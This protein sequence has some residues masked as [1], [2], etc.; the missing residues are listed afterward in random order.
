M[1]LT[2]AHESTALNETGLYPFV[3]LFK[4]FRTAFQG[5]LNE[6]HAVARETCVSGPRPASDTYIV[7][8]LTSKR[9][10]GSLPLVPPADIPWKDKKNVAVFRGA[11]TGLGRDGF[12]QLGMN[13]TDEEKCLHVQRCK[14]VYNTFGS[15]IVDAYITNPLPT[16][17][18]PTRIGDVQLTGPKCTLAE[19]LK[20][21]AI[22]M[23]EG[24]DVSSGFKW[25]LYSNSVVLTQKPR[26]SA[27]TMEDILEPWV[28]YV[29]LNSDLSDV[30]EKMQW[31]ID[32]DEE[33]QRIAKRAALWMKDLLYHPDSQKDEQ[34]IYEETIRRYRDHFVASSDL[35]L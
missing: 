14:L 26:L 18:L 19:M 22:I 8:R 11:P 10:F 2:K 31:V 6:V 34:A 9:H 25:A 33:A 23:L 1:S 5:G 7:W 32:H 29:P 27:W 21:K 20:Y 13:A 28:H 15:P 16:N 35:S 17:I 30:E 12:H 3:P 4:K 24:N